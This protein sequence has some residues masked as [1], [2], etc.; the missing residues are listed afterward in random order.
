MDR[1]EKLREKWPVG[2]R[3][4]T[5]EKASNDPLKMRKAHSR[6]CILMPLRQGSRISQ[7]IL[8]YP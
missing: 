7:K 2:T 5:K 1:P 4:E 8:L 3:G 6:I